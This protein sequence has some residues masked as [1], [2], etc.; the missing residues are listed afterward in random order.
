MLDRHV[1][2]GEKMK[3]TTE[4]KRKDRSKAEFE[5]RDRYTNRQT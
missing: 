2:K 1:E 5:K 3:N 4:G